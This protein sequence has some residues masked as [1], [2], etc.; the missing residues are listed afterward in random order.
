MTPTPNTDARHCPMTAC[1]A[2]CTAKTC[3][4]PPCACPNCLARRLAARG[5]LPVEAAGEG[6]LFEMPGESR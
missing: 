3:V 1:A 6:T 5:P 2:R 4:C